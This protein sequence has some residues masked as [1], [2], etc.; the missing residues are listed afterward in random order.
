MDSNHRPP[1]CK[2]RCSSGCLATFSE[3]HPLKRPA[4]FEPTTFGL[5]SRRSIQL[6]YGRD[7][8]SKQWHPGEQL[9]L[10][11]RHAG[12]GQGRR[13]AAQVVLVKHSVLHASLRQARAQTHQGMLV[14]NR[15]QYKVRTVDLD[16]VFAGGDASMASLDGLVAE[17]KVAANDCIH[18]VNLRHVAPG[19][20]VSI[21]SLTS[22]V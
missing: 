20:G 8:S 18:S 16:Q 11:L 19:I 4:G 21:A 5:E 14:R 17:G 13:S 7:E 12:G 22:Q 6:S 2:A 1:G 15:Q 9:P 10:L 3:L